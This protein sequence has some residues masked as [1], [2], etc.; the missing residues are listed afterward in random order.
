MISL[1]SWRSAR[2]NAIT[3]LGILALS[4][5]SSFVFSHTHAWSHS[6]IWP[7]SGLCLALLLRFGLRIVPAIACGLILARILNPMAV[8]HNPLIPASEFAEIFIGWYLLRKCSKFSLNLESTYDFRVLYTYSLFGTFLR[9]AVVALQKYSDGDIAF[10]S[11]PNTFLFLGMSHYLGI[12]VFTP[13]FL[14]V[15][16]IMP[17]WKK[18]NLG[19]RNVLPLLLMVTFVLIAFCSSIPLNFYPLAFL[20]VPFLLWISMRGETFV[21]ASAVAFIGLFS[22]LFT[23]NGMGPL[24]QPTR[25]IITYGELWFY[26]VAVTAS[27]MLVTALSRERH[28]ERLKVDLSIQCGQ[29]VLWEWNSK[30]GLCT[31]DEKFSALIEQHRKSTTSLSPTHGFARDPSTGLFPWEHSRRVFNAGDDLN[32]QITLNDITGPMAF[33]FKGRVQSIAHNG[34][35]TAILGVARDITHER[36]QAESI[37]IQALRDVELLNLRNSLNPH[38]LFNSLN[39]IKSLIND[40]ADKASNALVSLSMILRRSLESTHKRCTALREELESMDAYLQLQK[41]RFEDRLRTE[42]IS[43]PDH[44]DF[45]LPPLILHQLVENA[46][47]HCIGK[48]NGPAFVAIRT[49]NKDDCLLISVINSGKIKRQLTEGIGMKSIRAQLNSQYGTA[50]SFIIRNTQ[51]GVHAEIRMPF[52]KNPVT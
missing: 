31:N 47:K 2:H 51:E 9:G 38:F 43:P 42:I 20:P 40:N 39:M 23:I 46:F 25:D 44:G 34:A 12:I 45:M 15:P 37:M 35:A 48:I 22:C 18:I 50:A 8:S 4:W 16:I 19:E 5:G 29:L 52:E 7:T 36:E 33:D 28:I 10:G 32:F 21:A 27:S 49:E 11:I 14:L 3:A 13:F 24:T 1:F 26:L 30:T 6:P 17:N 41:L